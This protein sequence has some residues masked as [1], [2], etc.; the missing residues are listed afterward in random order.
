[1]VISASGNPTT[2]HNCHSGHV[3][4]VG[5]RLGW[6]RVCWATASGCEKERIFA[7]REAAMRASLCRSL[8]W[9]RRDRRFQPLVDRWVWHNRK[10]WPANQVK[11]GPKRPEIEEKEG[12]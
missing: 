11:I 12:I 1:M 6:S 10:K 3:P 5:L 4:E 2:G 7:E 8:C 9:R